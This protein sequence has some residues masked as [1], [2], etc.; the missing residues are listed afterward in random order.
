MSREAVIL[1]L[2][3]AAQ[4]AAFADRLRQD[5]AATT[6]G[7]DL[8]PE[9]AEALAKAD[10]QRVEELVGGIDRRLQSWYERRG[11]REQ[12]P[13]DGETEA[14]R[15]A[16]LAEYSRRGSRD[17]IP[18][19]QRLQAEFGYLSE[20]SMLAVSK[21]TG[22][23]ESRVFGVASFYAQ[24]RF[25]PSGRKKVS[26][27]RGTACHVR[28]AA[29]LLDE[30]EKLLGIKVGETTPDREFSLETVACIGC[31]ALSPCA[32]VDDEV[33]AKLTRATLKD[34]LFAKGGDHD[35]DVR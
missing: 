2:E 28:G 27:C 7:Y 6:V 9:E 30:A 11:P 17:L 32:V 34:A 5:F 10:G 4:D 18:L 16:I 3:R 12:S 14:R 13:G 25:T 31:C 29:A 24:F 19:L 26:V 33:H 15:D 20:K 8:A 23:P 22:V 35:G 1:L 21:Y